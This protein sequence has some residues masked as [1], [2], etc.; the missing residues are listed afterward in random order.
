MVN[1]SIASMDDSISVDSYIDKPTFEEILFVNPDNKRA[2]YYNDKTIECF[3]MNQL[4]EI[5][6]ND[7]LDCYD[8][9][10]KAYYNNENDFEFIEEINS[11]SVN[12]ESEIKSDDWKKRIFPELY[13]DGNRLPEYDESIL[14]VYVQNLPEYSHNSIIV[15]VVDDALLSWE[16][17]NPDVKFRQVSESQG[18]DIEIKWVTEIDFP[19]HVMGITE[20]EITEYLDG[21][22]ISEHHE[23]LIDL[24]DVD[25]NGNPVYWNKNTITDTIKHELGHA[26]GIIHHSSNEN[27]LMYDPDDGI[28]NV[29]THGLVIPKKISSEYYVEQKELEE[30]LEIQDKKFT[31]T[32]ANYGWTVDDWELD[33]K[34]STNE[35][36]YFKINAIVDEMN[37][38]IDETNCFIESTNHYDPYGDK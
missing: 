36:F 14:K 31:S 28:N 35:Q 4:G 22:F 2:L 34:S 6:T 13:D 37:P 19:T 30:L 16:E 32:L 20:S 27:H 11:D 29:L 24:V 18:S 3:R 12:T 26:L 15:G 33:L 17:L 25:C 38:L 1:L 23:I 21:G 9:Q 10:K 8:E 5:G 7:L